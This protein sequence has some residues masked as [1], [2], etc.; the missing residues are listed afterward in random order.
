LSHVKDDYM[1]KCIVPVF[2]FCIGNFRA[3]T[4]LG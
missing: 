1:I 3:L 2:L 4:D